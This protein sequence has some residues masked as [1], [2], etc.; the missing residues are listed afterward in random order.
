MPRGKPFEKGNSGKPKG[1]PNKSTLL[2]EA[3]QAE[4]FTPEGIIMATWQ[5]AMEDDDIQSATKLACEIMGKCFVAP[6]QEQKLTI[7]DES[8]KTLA[9]FFPKPDADMDK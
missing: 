8:K 6:P 3:L 2:R 9:D 4:G 5:K 1:T 7:N